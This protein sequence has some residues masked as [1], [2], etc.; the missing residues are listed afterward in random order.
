MGAQ[1][2]IYVTKRPTAAVIIWWF[3][4]DRSTLNTTG[5]DAIMREMQIIKAAPNKTLFQMYRVCGAICCAISMSSG[6]G[7]AGGE[8]KVV[9][10]F[11]IPVKISN[12][13]H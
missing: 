7:V 3:V 2:K 6:A 10:V 4:C 13:R 11:S 12:S 1:N 8:S 9:F 5:I